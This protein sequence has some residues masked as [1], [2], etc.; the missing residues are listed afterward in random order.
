MVADSGMRALQLQIHT[1]RTGLL[2]AAGRS[3]DAAD[4]RR[5]AMDL[6]NEIADGIRDDEI[7]R[8]FRRSTEDQLATATT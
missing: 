4:T 2:E 5:T 7:R 6:L 3:E 1:L 8:A